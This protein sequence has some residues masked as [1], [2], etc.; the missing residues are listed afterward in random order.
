[1]MIII[2][3]SLKK[4]VKYILEYT[5]AYYTRDM[6]SNRKKITPSKRAINDLRYLNESID[7]INHAF[8]DGKDGPIA[9]SNRF[10][11]WRLANKNT[12]EAIK[13]L[14]L[15]YT[16]S[17]KNETKLDKELSVWLSSKDNNYERAVIA[18]SRGYYVPVLYD[19]N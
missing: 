16:H 2:E 12:K 14:A 11:R 19:I 3:D 13:R 4:R 7:I 5:D 18:L 6:L 15:I 10:K 1:M 17:L 8:E 9:I